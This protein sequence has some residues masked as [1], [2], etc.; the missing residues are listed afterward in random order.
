MI[1]LYTCFH[2]FAFNLTCART[3]R[4]AEEAERAAGEAGEEAA[5]ISHPAW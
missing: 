2:A 1:L 3:P 4:E 5:R